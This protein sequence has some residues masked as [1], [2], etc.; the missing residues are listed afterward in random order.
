MCLNITKS[1]TIF[2]CNEKKKQAFSNAQ[3]LPLPESGG[4]KKSW[5]SESKMEIFQLSGFKK[6]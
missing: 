4:E 5:C 6:P 1:G 2:K 3:A